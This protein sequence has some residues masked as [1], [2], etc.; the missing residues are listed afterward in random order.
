MTW[1]RSYGQWLRGPRG[2]RLTWVRRAGWL[3]AALPAEVLRPPRPAGGLGIERRARAAD[4]LGAQPL[5]EGYDLPGERR[6][7]HGVRTSPSLGAFFQFLVRRRRPDVVVEFGTAFGVSGMYWLAALERE[8]HGQLL[9]FEPNEAWA[10]IARANLEATGSRFTAVVGT[11]EDHVDA[12]L[13]GRPIDVAFID[14]I[15]TRAWVSPQFALV[16]ERL[17]PGGLVLLDDIDFSAE[18]RACWRT[19]A[20]G[21]RVEGAVEVGGRVGV[22]ALREGG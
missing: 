21:P 13:R 7:P 15:H 9:T 6:R 5:W 14:A 20:G 18:M 8:G 11:F 4:G 3:A 17:S 22:L 16:Q 12:S 19:L 10:A 1:L 2:L